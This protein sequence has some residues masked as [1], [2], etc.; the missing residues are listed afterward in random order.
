[1][2]NCKKCGN[3]LIWQNDFD[4]GDYLIEDKEGIITVYL[5]SN[6][7]SIHEFYIDE[8]NDI[9]DLVILNMDDDMD[10]E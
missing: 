1:M 3:R 6:C 2:Y 8:N 7:N 9:E 10:E 5:C 4:Y